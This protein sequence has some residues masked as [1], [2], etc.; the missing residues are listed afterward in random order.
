MW[1][2]RRFVRQHPRYSYGLYVFG[3]LAVAVLL[4]LAMM[5]TRL[6][7]TDWLPDSSK[8]TSDDGVIF[9]LPVKSENVSTSYGAVVRYTTAIDRSLEFK[10]TPPATTIDEFKPNPRLQASACPNISGIRPVSPSDCKKA[11]TFK[12]NPVYQISRSLPSFT[13]ES[14]VKVDGTFIYVKA[15]GE[16]MDYLNTFVSF[17]RRGTGNYLAANNKRAD[18]IINKRLAEQA[19]TRR[20]NAAAYTYLNFT[21][22]L[23]AVV[24]PG[25]SLEGNNPKN[26]RIDGPDAQHPKLVSTGY[27]V[28]TKNGQKDDGVAWYSGNL[29][30]FV[31]M[32]YCGPSPGYSMEKL[33]CTKIPG[34]DYYVAELYDMRN[35]FVRYTYAPVGS[36]LVITSLVKISEDGKPVPR[37]SDLIAAQDLIAKSAKPINKNSLKGSTYE[38]VFYDP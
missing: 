22:A 32:G 2:I 15:N 10:D 1:K 3:I 11:G 9:S 7:G 19:E 4:F 29:V 25:W 24:P 27:W 18:Q 16:G 14:F 38:R 31:V 30:D 34:E 13:V 35:D 21:P 33:P 36:S 26:I 20:V 23:A 37:P 6:P 28:K 5:S 12:G 17:P 8:Y